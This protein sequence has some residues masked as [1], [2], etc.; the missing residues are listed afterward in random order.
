MSSFFYIQLPAENR[1]IVTGHFFEKGKVRSPFLIADH[2]R[3]FLLE[4]ENSGLFGPHCN[5]VP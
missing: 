3:Q 2:P 5:S 4:S 1:R